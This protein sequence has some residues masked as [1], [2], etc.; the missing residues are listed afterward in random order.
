MK[1]L[2]LLLLLGGYMLIYAS[3]ANRGKFAGNPWLGLFADAYGQAPS[4]GDNL[5]AY[6]E[7]IAQA[8]GS[9]AGKID[10]GLEG[11]F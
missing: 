2:S 6:S 5:A 7:D 8:A 9:I 11:L 1:F 4:P 10:T 3:V